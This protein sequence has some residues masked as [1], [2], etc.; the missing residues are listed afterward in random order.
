MDKLKRELTVDAELSHLDD[1]VGFVEDLLGT[2]S[3]PM[4]LTMQVVLCVEEL[5]VN[6]ASYAYG[7]QKGICIINLET[8][9]TDKQG[10]VSIEIIDF[11]KPFNPLEKEDPDTT[12]SADQRQIGGLGIYMVK[13][14]MDR[15]TYEYKDGKN[16]LRL[17]K[18]WGIL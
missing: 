11:G 4:K 12:L 15:V 14:S 5:F 16:I 17:E 9:H 1:V 8:Q 6:V 18:S 10:G 2:T 3:C 7:D 13:Q